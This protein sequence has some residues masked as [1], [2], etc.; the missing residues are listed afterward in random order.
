MKDT[1][2]AIGLAITAILAPIQPML[3]TVGCL[4]LADLVTGL[5]RAFKLDERITSKALSR[6]V[7]KMLAYQMTVITAFLLEKYLI[8]GA[9][10][11]A[12]L[13]ASIIGIT[14]FKSLL[15]NTE[16]ITGKPVF[17]TIIE[18]LNSKESG[19]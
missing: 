2:L 7:Y 8:D 13:V 5:I 4:I 14:E 18:K 19:K 10:P 17:K 3:I 9:L 1:L 16:A 11:A 6:S 12:K 15:E